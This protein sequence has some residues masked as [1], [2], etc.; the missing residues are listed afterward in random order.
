[1]NAYLSL[2]DIPGRRRRPLSQKLRLHAQFPVLAFEFPEARTLADR[3]RRLLVGV[4]LPVRVHPITEAALVNPELTGD[5][6][7]RTRRLDHHL[8]RLVLELR[9]EIP[10]TP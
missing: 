3:Q 2:T 1:M 4:L 10:A 9:R 8:D 5:G 7:D 6:S